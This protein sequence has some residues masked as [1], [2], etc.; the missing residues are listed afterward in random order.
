MAEAHASP[1]GKEGGRVFLVCLLILLLAFLLRLDFVLEVFERWSRLPQ[2]HALRDETGFLVR[3]SDEYLLPARSLLQGDVVN[4]G[5]ILRPPGYPFFLAL[6]GARALPILVAQATVASLA[7]F[8]ITLLTHRVTGSLALSTLAGLAT[9][10]SPTGVGVAGLLLPDLL[11]GVLVALGVLLTLVAAREGLSSALLSAGVVFGFAVL[12][13]P[14]LV[15]WSPVSLVLYWLF[16]GSRLRLVSRRTILLV[17]A[18]QLVPV[19]GWSARNLVTDGVFT[20]S[21]VGPAT[22]RTYLMARTE[23]R[24]AAG[25]GPTVPEI[26]AK[27]ADVRRRF[28]DASLGWR[29]KARQ[30]RKE[31]LEIF[32]THPIATILTYVDVVSDNL[33]GGWNCLPQ[34]LPELADS[35]LL[36]VA[37]RMEGRLRPLVPFAFL[38]SLLAT[39]GV[40]FCTR[41]QQSRPG[42]A[43][44]RRPI[45]CLGLLPS[46][47]QG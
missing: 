29:A 19:L 13:K 43:R 40:W 27:Q 23:A 14:I 4:A 17:V 31:N 5:D 22:A 2:E 20:L 26:R 18:F 35:T 37:S 12:V 39:A 24:V 34:Q 8:C 30:Y 47:C 46:P 33:S 21:T 6:F 11:L 42:D 7:P 28:D 15:F 36:V 1:S 32:L 25:R 16:A 41:T 44:R 10:L 38:A 3:D 9:A 45:M